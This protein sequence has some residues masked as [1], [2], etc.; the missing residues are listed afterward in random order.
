MCVPSSCTIT[1]SQRLEL[2]LT[3]GLNPDRGFEV[4]DFWRVRVDLEFDLAKQVQNSGFLEEFERVRCLV[5]VD[6]PG[7]K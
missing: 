7:F 6:E 1:S 5:L 2:V 4:R 3:V